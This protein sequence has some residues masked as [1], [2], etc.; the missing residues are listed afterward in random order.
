MMFRCFD[1]LE[2]GMEG[3]GQISGGRRA[4]IRL[5]CEH[6]IPT[7]KMMREVGVKKGEQRECPEGCGPQGIKQVESSD[8]SGV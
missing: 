7:M 1:F 4:H 6:V 3:W 5:K 8:W 2:V